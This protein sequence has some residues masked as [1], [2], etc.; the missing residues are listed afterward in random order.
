MLKVV[1]LWIKGFSVLRKRHVIYWGFELD[2]VFDGHLRV[3]YE[4]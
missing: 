1:A 2:V 4:R 3:F